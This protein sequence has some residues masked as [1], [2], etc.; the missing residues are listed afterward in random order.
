MQGWVSE[1]TDYD[2][3]SNTCKP[4]K[5]CGHYTQVVWRDTRQVGCASV[6]C[7]SNSPFQGHPQWRIWV[8]DY[9]P[10]GNYVGQKPY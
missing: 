2:L 5:I 8:C 3:A 9:A 10:P 6:V 4:G 7:N 1:S